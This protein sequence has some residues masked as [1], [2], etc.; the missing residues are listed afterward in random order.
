MNPESAW[1]YVLEQLDGTQIGRAARLCQLGGYNGDFRDR[2][3]TL[4]AP[5]RQTVRALEGPALIDALKQALDILNLKLIFEV[6]DLADDPLN[7]AWERVLEHFQSDWPRASFD[8]WIRGTQVLDFSDGI[9][10]I[11]ARNAYNRDWLT[12]RVQ[13]SSSALMSGLLGK[14]VEVNFVVPNKPAE[15]DDDEQEETDE[16]GGDNNQPEIIPAYDT[17]YDQVVKP[18]QRIALPGYALRSLKHGDLSPKEM[19]LWTAFRQATYHRWSKGEMAVKNIPYWDVLRYAN[20]SRSSLEREIARA[21]NGKLCGGLVS[22]L[23]EDET[24]LTHNPQYDYARRYQVQ[25]NP[26][27]TRRD[28][29]AIHSVLYRAVATT[30]S[31]PDALTAAEKTLKELLDAQPTSYLDAAE[32]QQHPTGGWPRGVVEIVR[33]VTGHKGDLPQGVHQAAEQLQERIVSGFG[34]AMITLYFLHTVSPR[35]QLTQAEMWAAIVLRYRCA[36]DPTENENLGYALFHGGLD[37]LAERSG[38]STK[39]L[40]RWMEKPSFGMFA[41]IEAVPAQDIPR[42][43]T[44]RSILFDVCQAEPIVAAGQNDTRPRTKCDTGLDKMTHDP[45]QNDTRGWTKCDTTLDKMTHDPGQNDTRL[46][47]FIKF[48]PISNKI[49]ESPQTPRQNSAQKTGR[50]ESR[51]YWVWDSLIARNAV[52]TPMSKKILI[53]NKA[54][55]QEIARLCQRFVS[56]ILYGYSE[57]GRGLSDPIANALARMSENIYASPGGDLDRLAAL[58]PN[59]LRAFLDLDLAGR[60]LPDSHHADM[61]KFHFSHLPDTEK[62]D[63]RTRLFG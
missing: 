54:A 19:T 52:S 36:Y 1:Q 20:M 23:P 62:R 63:L 17:A 58:P 61:Y 22:I 28:C 48:Q 42:H 60:E 32:N 35:L 25:V 14:N 55:N 2:S 47:R 53:A 40:K 24:D 33:M 12:E 26:R 49:H 3:L 43:W 8:T 45:G 6:R 7:D 50:V 30:T 37:E 11:A 9:L 27:L 46:K 16:N 44:P 57:A 51:A 29:N 10:T 41:R 21:N 4:L 18:E 5:N 15:T 39:S 56:W 59:T 13:E 34:L 38:M 31:I